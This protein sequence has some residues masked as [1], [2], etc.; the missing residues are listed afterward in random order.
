MI[1][2]WLAMF[3]ALLSERPYPHY[4]IQ[5][6]VPGTILLA[7]FL[8]NQR[9]VLK[10]V[11]VI[12]AILNGWWWYQIKFWGYPLVSYYINF[13]QYITGQKSLE[14]YRNYFDP[15]VN[16]TYRLGEYLKRSTLPQDRVFIWGDEPGVYA[17]AERLPLGRYA[18]AYHVVDF[19]DYEATIKA[20]GKQPP[21]VVLVMDY[22]KRPFKE[23]ELKLA[24]DYVLAGKID[25]ARV[26]RFLEGK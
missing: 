7:L 19:N 25:Q 16:Q 5:P 1:W 20:W 14:E 2:F 11:I 22:E 3:G 17:L 18:V 21:K 10:L 13:G 12:A 24:T 15:R 9:K 6:A 8:S 26:Y 4:L 23:M